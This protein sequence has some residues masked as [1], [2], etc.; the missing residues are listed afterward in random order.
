MSFNFD[1]TG[2]LETAASIFN[3]F[4]PLFLAIGGIGVGLAL[5]ARVIVEVRKAI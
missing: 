4:A 3:S 2:L 5:L 1:L